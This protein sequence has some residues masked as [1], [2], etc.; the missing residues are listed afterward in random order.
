MFESQ[1]ILSNVVLPTTIVLLAILLLRLRSRSSL[2]KSADGVASSALSGQQRF[3]ES[4][5]WESPAISLACALSVWGAMGI[6]NEFVLWPDDAWMRIPLATGIVSLAGMKPLWL[7]HPIAVW[8]ARG[9]ALMAATMMVFPRGESWE[10]LQ[11]SLKYWFAVI[12]SSSLA[13]WWLIDRRTSREGGVL[14]IGWIACVAAGA[15][16]TSQSFLKVTE[17]LLAVASIF[18]W[19]GI[20][21]FWWP[22]SRLVSTIAGPSLFALSAAIASAQFNSFLGLP[23]ALSWLAVAS[24]AI[25]AFVGSWFSVPSQTSD[26]PRIA[27]YAIVTIALCLLLAVAVIVWTVLAGEVGSESW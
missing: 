15:F 13:G 14:G 2:Q 18:G 26:A 10:F 16:L 24:P 20:A 5:P 7:T 8:S 11:L 19:T 27:R 25:A 22:Q 4:G 3:Q 1:I 9:A 23:D 12:V 6:R 21:A 17:P